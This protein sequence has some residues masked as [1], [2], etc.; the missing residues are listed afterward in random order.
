MQN[1]SH[2]LQQRAMNIRQPAIRR[3]LSRFALEVGN[4]ALF[5]LHFPRLEVTLLTGTAGRVIYVG[6]PDGFMVSLAQALFPDG[7]EKT[8]LG[9]TAVWKLPRQTHDWL[10]EY[11]LVFN[12]ISRFFPWQPR[13]T[14]TFSNVV[15][16]YQILPLDKPFDEL[17]AGGENRRIRKETHRM[18]RENYECR[19]S[20]DEADLRY[21]YDRI[22]LPTTDRR[23]GEKALIMPYE[24]VKDMFQHGFLVC[25]SLDNQM[26]AMDLCT[27]QDGTVHDM[28][29]GV[30]DGD[31]HWMEREAGIASYWYVI[32][33]AYDLG[34]HTVNFKVSIAW[35]SD[36]VF[37]FKQRWGCHAAPYPHVNSQL[38]VHANQLT[39]TWRTRIN[40]IGFITRQADQ[41]LLVQLDDS[42]TITIEDRVTLARKNGLAGVRLIRSTGA[43]SHFA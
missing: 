16:V 8:S 29:G 34:A 15:S 38:L 23:H 30:L 7:Y 40:E 37:H 28:I 6:D 13:T 11:D 25:L 20:H 24:A 9:R 41:F 43:Q 5:L 10:R 3:L 36:G 1:G 17:L 27:L 42:S 31:Q 19:I 18:R 12:K 35:I 2:R 39:D 22:Y 26:V 14:Y 21:F 32:K 33:T 4:I